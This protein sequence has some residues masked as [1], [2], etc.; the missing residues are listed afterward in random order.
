[1]FLRVLSLCAA[2][3]P[4]RAH[5]CAAPFRAEGDDDYTPFTPCRARPR[6]DVNATFRDLV[7]GTPACRPA[8]GR[9]ARQSVRRPD[10]GRRL[11][12]T[13]A[14]ADLNGDDALRPARGFVARREP[15]RAL[16]AETAASAPRSPT[17]SACYHGQNQLDLE[18][19]DADGDGDIDVLAVTA[20]ST[21]GTL[22]EARLFRNLGTAR[23][24]WS[25]S[26]PAR[27][28]W[29]PSAWSAASR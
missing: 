24:A 15:P 20:G 6:G 11:G 29:A 27:P 26:S 19:A 28:D 16:G 13:V 1:M 7:Y 3:S 4:R 8:P 17:R 12:G 5:E 9:W 22:G 2:R 14:L 10:R 23:W 18:T 21:T 25:V